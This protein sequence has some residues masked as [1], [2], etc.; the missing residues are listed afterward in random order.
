MN[1]LV[2]SG[3]LKEINCGNNLTYV[4]SDE[5]QFAMTKYKILQNYDHSCFVKCMK[6]YFNGKPQLYYLTGKYKPLSNIVAQLDTASFLTILTNLFQSIKKVRENGFL[7]CTN[8]DISLEHIFVDVSMRKVFL[9]YVPIFESFFEDETEFENEFRTSLARMMINNAVLDSHEIAILFSN[10]QNTM[11]PFEEIMNT[12]DS[13]KGEE[14]APAHRSVQSYPV[15]QLELRLISINASEPVVL[16][17]NKNDYIVGRSKK[18]ADGVID[19]GKKM[20]GRRHCMIS[21]NGSDYIVKDLN[22]AN[23]TYLNM[24][25]LQP[26]MGF[27]LKNGDTLQLANIEF[28][29]MIEEQ[30]RI[31]EEI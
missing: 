21:W 27:K 7:T 3:I 23:H 18:M 4:M 30:G 29:A 14:V 20:I 12:V 5:N 15:I 11:L 8:I 10:L 1:R 16:N 6:I 31:Y 13:G 26:Q 22:S 19:D 9:V 25:R 24:V 17:V 28:K 2:E